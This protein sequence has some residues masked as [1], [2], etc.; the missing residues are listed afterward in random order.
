MLTQS[1]KIT[2]FPRKKSQRQSTNRKRVL[3]ANI[4]ETEDTLYVESEL[5][6]V[7]LSDIELK[8]VG[9]KLSIKISRNYPK[10]QKQGEFRRRERAMGSFN[11]VIELP[12]DIYPDNVEA[13]LRNG[14]LTILLPK[15]EAGKSTNVIVRSL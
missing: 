14:I 4:C 12:T 2:P 5:P 1:V 3:A 13:M 10:E 11:R 7:T 9:R 15:M 8:I 6:G